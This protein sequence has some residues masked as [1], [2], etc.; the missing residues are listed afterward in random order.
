MY[1]FISTYEGTG[2]RLRLVLSSV[3]PCSCKFDST[4]K[5]TKPPHG[6]EVGLAVDR[7]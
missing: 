2:G 7:F 6:N 4:I 5:L 3:V 1:N